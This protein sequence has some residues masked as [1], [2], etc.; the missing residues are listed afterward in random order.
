MLVQQTCKINHLSTLFLLLLLDTFPVDCFIHKQE[1][2]SSKL[3]CKTGAVYCIAFLSQA[4]VGF[5]VNEI[6]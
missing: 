6:Y 2:N 3:F 4:A 5:A 1:F